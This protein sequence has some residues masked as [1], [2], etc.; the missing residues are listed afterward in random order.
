MCCEENIFYCQCDYC[1]VD[2]AIECCSG[3][4]A[5]SAVDG[6]V[7]KNILCIFKSVTG[8]LINGDCFYF[9]DAVW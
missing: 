6:V 9:Y 7:V 2:S 1:G 3:G 4:V 8:R 5:H